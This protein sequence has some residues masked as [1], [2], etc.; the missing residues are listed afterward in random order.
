M[1]RAHLAG[2]VRAGVVALASVQTAIAG[3]IITGNG[4]SAVAGSSPQVKAFDGTTLALVQSFLPFGAG[5]S[6]G[7]RVAAGDVNHDGVPDYIAG[8]GNNGAVP[9]QVAVFSGTDL[10][11]LQSFLPYGGYMGSVF[12]GSADVNGDGTGDVI[13]GAGDGG[14]TNVKVFSGSSTLQLA[15]FSAYPGFNGAVRVAAGDVNGDGFADIVTGP[16]AGAGPNVKVFDGKTGVLLKSY[17]AY[18]PSFAGGIFVA[19]GDLNGDGKADIVT[20]SG[21][22]GTSNVK[23]FSGADDTLLHSFLAYSG[24]TDEVRVAV[25]DV[26]G[27][28]QN[29]I[30]TGIGGGSSLVKVFDG[31]SIS[32]LNSFLAYP[33]STD[34]VYV[35]AVPVPEPSSLMMLAIGIGIVAGWRV[36]GPANSS[37]T[38]WH[39]RLGPHPFQ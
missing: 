2:L 29:D 23:V 11:T 5:V 12:V 16:S 24:S 9:A 35:A 7:V 26:N 30:V 28:G 13:T 18:D 17:F 22:G 3:Q 4:E 27:D 1:R 25:G 39:R 20:G 33:G 31:A 36:A 8:M 34:G 10:S 21:S 15:S 14:G 32:Q 19:A 37:L 38:R 6:G